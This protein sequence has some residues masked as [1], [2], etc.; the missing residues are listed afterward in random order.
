MTNFKVNIYF[1]HQFLRK[2]KESPL[3]MKAVGPSFFW[4]QG[5]LEIAVL[6]LTL[7]RLHLES[8]PSQDKQSPAHRTGGFHQEYSVLLSRL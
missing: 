6:N 2:K 7:I 1:L 4:L 3:L 5:L 8:I